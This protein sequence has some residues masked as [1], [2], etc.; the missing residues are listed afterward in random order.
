MIQDERYRAAE[1]D[2]RI[3]PCSRDDIARD[4]R[5]RVVSPRKYSHSLPLIHCDKYDL[6]RVI[7][8]IYAT[9]E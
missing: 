9:H 4:A 7:L 2:I 6:M 1:I 8:E 5:E 3:L